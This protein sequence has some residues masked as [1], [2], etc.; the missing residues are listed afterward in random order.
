MFRKLSA[1][2]QTLSNS[3]LAALR[4]FYRIPI[5]RDR[6]EVRTIVDAIMAANGV[7]NTLVVSGDMLSEADVNQPE[8]SQSF[9]R[10]TDNTNNTLKVNVTNITD[11][12]RD[13]LQ[14]VYP[15]VHW[16]IFNPSIAWIENNTYLVSARLF[17]RHEPQPYQNNPWVY[18]A[19][20]GKD[21]TGLFLIKN[22]RSV[23]LNIIP[24]FVD[25]RLFKKQDSTILMI[26][27]QGLNPDKDCPDYRTILKCIKFK[28]K[29]D[30]L[31]LV[32]SKRLC[33]HFSCHEKNWSF[34]QP[35]VD[36]SA[37]NISYSI[38]TAHSFYHYNDV[39]DTC[40]EL[41]AVTGSIDFHAIERYYKDC[42]FAV[43]LSTPIIP[44]NAEKNTFIG[45]GHVKFQ[46]AQISTIFEYSPLAM[47]YSTHLIDTDKHPGYI[48]MFFFF[49]IQSNGA[50]IRASKIIHLKYGNSSLVF[51]S[52][53]SHTP[54]N[55]LILS[56]GIMDRYAV[57]IEFS[58]DMVE[59]L[60][61][62]AEMGWNVPEF[63]DVFDVLEVSTKSE[64][65]PLLTQPTVFL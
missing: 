29:N 24:D 19:W 41:L 3:D 4:A 56:A 44:W 45:V 23:F 38:S 17:T 63:N 65:T 42:S 32:G 60:F 35:N 25:V 16:T 36:D 51:P 34:W 61:T 8:K 52:G 40:S 9:L 27:N 11:S 53:L 43:S 5:Q 6:T 22:E 1:E 21:I 18:P 57:L 12:L 46:F 64:Y 54:E 55:Q 30:K 33:P 49:E 26:G 15:D 58:P 14:T 7:S 37:V 47:F 28:I 59:N 48:Y 62:D 31:E 13:N 2:L 50:V 39:T 20:R 10:K